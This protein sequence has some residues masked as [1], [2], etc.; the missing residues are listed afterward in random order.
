[1]DISRYFGLLYQKKCLKLHFLLFF[2]IT[3]NP[4]EFFKAFKLHLN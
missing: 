3:P 1:M 4:S 2:S